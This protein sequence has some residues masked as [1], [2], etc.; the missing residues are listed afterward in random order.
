MTS[1][2]SRS[3]RLNLAQLSH[4]RPNMSGTEQALALLGKKVSTCP[5]HFVHASAETGQTTR[6]RSQYQSPKEMAQHGSEWQSCP[7]RSHL[8]F[9]KGCVLHLVGPISIVRDKALGRGPWG[10]GNVGLD[11]V[12]PN[13]CQGPWIN[14][15]VGGGFAKHICR[16]ITQIR[17]SPTP[18]TLDQI[19]ELGF[20]AL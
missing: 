14:C 3:L 5:C 15:E 17:T 20:L 19:Q 11:V 6:G 18:R 12:T 10:V 7:S 16:A 13:L 4:S 9:L 1:S 8:T 2:C